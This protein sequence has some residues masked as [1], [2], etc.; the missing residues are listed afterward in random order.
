MKKYITINKITYISRGVN[1]K[2][3]HDLQ[4]CKTGQRAFMAL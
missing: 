1:S 4:N 3:L 2:G